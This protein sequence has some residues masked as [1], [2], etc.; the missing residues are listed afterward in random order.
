MEQNYIENERMPN[1]GELG[2]YNAHFIE[3][4][5]TKASILHLK[6]IKTNTSTKSTIYY[7][8]FLKC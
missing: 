3:H 4:F 5:C 2:S 6:F 1:F 8:D 7:R